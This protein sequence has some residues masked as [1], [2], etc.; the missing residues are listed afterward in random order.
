MKSCNGARSRVV[1]ASLCQEWFLQQGI[2]AAAPLCLQ[3]Q[4][5]LPV[6]CCIEQPP[7]PPS[8]FLRV[9]RP[10]NRVA[11]T[12]DFV[13]PMRCWSPGNPAVRAPVRPY[14]NDL[15]ARS[16]AG[17]TLGSTRGSIFSRAKMDRRVKHGDDAGEWVKRCPDQAGEPAR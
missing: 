7:V 17:L 16:P 5:R 6:V 15:V 2:P 8:P 11:V 1:R 14:P 13:V 4:A 3:V 9:R 12:N 10:S